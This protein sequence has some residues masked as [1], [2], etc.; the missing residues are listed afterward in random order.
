MP[1]KNGVPRCMQK[2]VGSQARNNGI[3][4]LCAWSIARRMIQYWLVT[5]IYH[6]AASS[7]RRF[8]SD[9]NGD[10]NAICYNATDPMPRPQELQ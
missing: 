1:G 10:A 7:N 2:T 6:P 8:D 4:R 5:E 9:F 3:P